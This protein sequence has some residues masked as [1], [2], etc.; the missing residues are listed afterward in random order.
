MELKKIIFIFL[1]LTASTQAEMILPSKDLSPSKVIQI[2]LSALKN[3]DSPKADNGIRQTWIFAHP[4]NKKIT[5]PYEKFK[6]MLYSVHYRILINHYSHSINLIMNNQNKYIYG[7][8]IL[9]KD[10]KQFLY[11]WHVEKGDEK[12][13]NDCWFTSVVSMPTSQ[14]NSI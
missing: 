8:K 9:S 1:F 3:N 11:E 5:G 12:D 2:Q 4:E 14:G 13:C 6:A 7:V 10:K